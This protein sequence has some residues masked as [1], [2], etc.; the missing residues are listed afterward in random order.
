MPEDDRPTTPNVPI[1]TGELGDDAWVTFRRGARFGSRDLPLGDLAGARRVG[2]LVTVLD[3]G[4]QSCPFHYHQLEEEHFYVLEGRCVLRSGEERHEMGP[5][6]YVCFPPASGV[7]H[8]F[9]N[10][11]DEPCRYLTVGTKEANEVCVYPDSGKV[12]IGSLDVM[13]RL[14]AESL[15]YWDGEPVD[16]ALEK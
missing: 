5:G 8:C 7:A 16:E 9:E 1:R 2:F 14:P 3:P 11:F 13:A 10:P 15:D 4:D 6:D 12:L